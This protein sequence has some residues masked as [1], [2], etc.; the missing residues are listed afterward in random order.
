MI[1]FVLLL[2]PPASGEPKPEAPFITVNLENVTL[3]YGQRVRLWC[4]AAGYPKPNVK[5]LKRI[6]TKKERSWDITT[7]E[8][9]GP[10]I[11]S[12]AYRVINRVTTNDQGWY[13]CRAK[14]AFGM[15]IARG[16]LTVSNPCDT[17]RCPEGK[18]CQLD[19]YRKRPT[20]RC[21]T[22]SCTDFDVVCGSDCQTYFSP[23]YLNAINCELNKNITIASPGFCPVAVSPT[24]NNSHQNKSI[25]VSKP[26]LVKCGAVGTPAPT[27]QWYH[28]LDEELIE[29]STGDELYIENITLAHSGIYF[30][31]ARS[32]GQNIAQ[33]SSFRVFVETPPVLPTCAVVGDGHVRTFSGHTYSFGGT[34]S[35]MLARDCLL[36][37]WFIYSR[38]GDCQ[39]KATCLEA[40]TI[41]H[42]STYFEI[43]RGWSVNMGFDHFVMA[44]GDVKVYDD[45][46]A[47]QFRMN[48]THMHV[49]LPDLTI[50][51]DGVS[52]AH[53]VLTDVSKNDKTCGLCGSN[54]GSNSPRTRSFS[55]KDALALVDQSRLDYWNQCPKSY[56]QA[57]KCSGLAKE[58]A[59][60]MCHKMFS[61]R[62]F[63][64]CKQVVDVRW[65]MESC[66]LDTC[67]NEYLRSY[68]SH[69]RAVDAFNEMCSIAG[70]DVSECKLPQCNIRNVLEGYQCPKGELPFRGCGPTL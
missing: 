50:I 63:S 18:V 26:L 13:Y 51:W 19:E 43:G 46:A 12:K 17:Y 55:D 47:L 49:L 38:F 54:G 66:I 9:D 57:Y 8:V 23:C 10:V 40:L 1:Y 21:P 11:A 16:Y 52:S 68:P 20:C 42:G 32:C 15:E 36:G 37:S 35:Y 53:I 56:V 7:N 28:Q 44:E 61:C 58:Q 22:A 45:Y 27:V 69:C 3:A 2:F 29:I 67:Q 4:E 39:T 41:Y 60:K 5:I 6:P 34:C 62:G 70:Y 24:I 25:A 59:T 64:L 30:C 31:Q 33:S 14:N 48:G 65:Y